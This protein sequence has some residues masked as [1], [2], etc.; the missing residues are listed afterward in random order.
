[1]KRVLIAAIAFLSTVSCFGMQ[2]PLNP[3]TV[4]VSPEIMETYLI[5]S[6]MPDYPEAAR[7]KHIRGEVVC[8]ITI[9]R[10]GDVIKAEV[11]K[12]DPA[13]ANAAL[14]AIKQWKY[15]TYIANDVPVNVETS[16]VIQFKK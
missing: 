2:G 4:H 13:L 14:D 16:A 8:K 5:H 3:A 9:S 1:M 11:V 6:A 10:Q 7:K 15:M 12:G